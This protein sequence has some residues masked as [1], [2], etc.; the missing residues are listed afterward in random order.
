MS[1]LLRPLYAANALLWG[2]DAVYLTVNG[3]TSAAILAVIFAVVALTVTIRF[4][5]WTYRS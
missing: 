2:F 4:D 5:P 3:F 1:G